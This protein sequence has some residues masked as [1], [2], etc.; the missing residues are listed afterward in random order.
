MTVFASLQMRSTT[1]LGIATLIL[2]LAGWCALASVAE[3]ADASTTAQQVVQIDPRTGKVVRVVPNG[4]TPG[5]V[6]AAPATFGRPASAA[7][8]CG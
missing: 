2:G 3:A 7:A 8:G 6:A 1:G 5:L 4:V